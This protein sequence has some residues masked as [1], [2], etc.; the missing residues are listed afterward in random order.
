MDGDGSDVVRITTDGK[1]SQPFISPD[2]QFVFYKS[3]GGT[4][5][6]VPIDGGP[7]ERLTENEVSHL[8][9]SPDGTLV[10]AGIGTRLVVFP[11]DGGPAKKEFDMT[12]FGTVTGNT[13]W[14]ADG[15]MI[16]YR[17]RGYGYWL[18]PVDGG[19]PQRM[20]GLPM[21]KFYNF[22]WS[23]DGKYFAFVRGQEIRDVVIFRQSDGR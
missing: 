20:V 9:L 19:E 11:V 12:R 21:E 7:A 5:H 6:R 18:Q 22:A 15:K 16:A 23:K 13:R 3:N 2:S 4:M 17:D 1:S 10:A 8:S 14:S